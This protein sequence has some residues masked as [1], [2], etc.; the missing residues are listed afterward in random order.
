LD[1]QRAK[2][3]GAAYRHDVVSACQYLADALGTP[4]EV[5][6]SMPV[7]VVVASDDPSTVDYPRRYGDWRLLAQHVDLHELADGG[8]YFL[9]TRPIETARAVLHAAALATPAM[10]TE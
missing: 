1:A 2:H 5:K 7:T 6:L 10:S 3:F 8:H 9:R 4:P